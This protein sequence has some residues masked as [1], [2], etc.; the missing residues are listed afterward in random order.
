MFCQNDFDCIFSIIWP[1]NIFFRTT[2]LNRFNENTIKKIILFDYLNN[3]LDL[4]KNISY[5]PVNYFYNTSIKF[6]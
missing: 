2:F 3:K 6:I 5:H 1:F 4:I